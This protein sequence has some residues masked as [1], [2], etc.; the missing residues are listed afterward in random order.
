MTEQ[1]NEMPLVPPSP[2]APEE[3]GYL[4]LHLRMDTDP[5]NFLS[6]T[7]NPSSPIP[8]LS[9]IPLSPLLPESTPTYITL[10]SPGSSEP[11]LPSS[12]GITLTGLLK[13]AHA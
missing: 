12:L 8:L 7:V 3:P 9:L 2:W 10:P 11:S 6:L 4:I 13:G 1:M 5:S